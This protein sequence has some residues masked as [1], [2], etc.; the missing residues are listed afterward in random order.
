MCTLNDFLITSEM[1]AVTDPFQ[2]SKLDFAKPQSTSRSL[3]KMDGTNP[4]MVRVEVFGSNK[5]NIK[6]YNEA[7]L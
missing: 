6:A 3:R 2:T 5:C 4:V 7:I 1:A